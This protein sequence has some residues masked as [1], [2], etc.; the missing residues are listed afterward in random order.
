MKLDRL[1][2]SLATCLAALTANAQGDFR[3]AA[4]STAAPSA[5]LAA[6][7]DSTLRRVPVYASIS[8]ASLG[9]TLPLSAAQ[10]LQAIGHHARREIGAAPGELP[11]ADARFTWRDLDG[12][13]TLWSHRDGT[14][15]WGVVDPEA[16]WA[17]SRA[18][19][20]LLYRA[21]GAARDSGQAVMVLADTVRADSVALHVSL[22]R[23][24]VDPAG[25][26]HP[27]EADMAIPLFS[28]PV[29]RETQVSVR[30]QAK[31]GFPESLRRQGVEGSVI[32]EFTVDTTGIA[33][34]STLSDAGADVRDALPR[35]KRAY[36][37][38]MFRSARSM[39]AESLYNPATINGCR[40]RQKVRQPFSWALAG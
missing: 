9:H 24:T 26:M 14:I 27:A 38:R 33:D 15:T 32:L 7:P 18:G 34:T 5:C 1:C 13:L 40:V 28:V 21:L 12:H 30:R 23:P 3:P 11:D 6:I 29:P 10:L 2:V 37:D 31:K 4:P 35:E 39:I 19:V 22:I 17:R 25:V 20:D 36:Y 16:P 8:F